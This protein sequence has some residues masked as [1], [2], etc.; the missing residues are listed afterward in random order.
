MA[1]CRNAGDRCKVLRPW[2]G[3][4]WVTTLPLPLEPQSILDFIEALHNAGLSVA[5]VNQLA[6][7]NP[8]LIFWPKP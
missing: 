8:V 6:K 4:W 1:R 7:I 2:N 3:F 5:D